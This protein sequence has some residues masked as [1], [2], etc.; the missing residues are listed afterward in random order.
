MLN[1]KE[2][3]GIIIFAVGDPQYGRLAYNLAITLKKAGEISITVVRTVRSL[4]HLSED[5]LKYFDHIIDLPD[6]APR[7]CGAKL[8]AYDLSPYQKTLLLD[9]DMLWLPEKMPGEIFLDLE[10]IKFTSITEGFSPGEENKM[11]FFWADVKEIREKY[12]IK[13]ERLY[14]WRSEVMYFERCTETK[15]FFATAKK[16]FKKPGLNSEKKFA[17]GTADELAVGIAAGVHNIEPHQYKWK[18]S[19]WHLM[20][21]NAFPDL[22]KLYRDYYLVSFGARFATENS[23][24]LY[25]RIVK[26]TCYK[27]GLQHV[28]PLIAKK[29]YLRERQHI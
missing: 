12:D 20:N 21:N 17:G 24:L 25:D 26:A 15:K 10:G 2:D 4:S 6:D 8:W 13:C 11:Y 27:L 19:Y 16:I 9:A 7:G 3:K 5:K 23:K 14:Q 1:K 29:E 28:F 18:P 22:T